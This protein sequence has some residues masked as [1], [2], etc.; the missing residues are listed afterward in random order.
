MP[1]TIAGITSLGTTGSVLPIKVVDDGAG[2]GKV[3]CKLE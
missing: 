2:L 1:E 3:V